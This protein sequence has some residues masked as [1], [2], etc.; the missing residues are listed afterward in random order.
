M[1]NKIL[2]SLQIGTQMSSCAIFNGLLSLLFLIISLL[3][4]FWGYIVTQNYNDSLETA[5]CTV[6][7]STIINKCSR[8]NKYT[9]ACTSQVPQWTTTVEFSLKNGWKYA[10][11]DST[12]GC[13]TSVGRC[14]AHFKFARTHPV[15]KSSD[16]F[17]DQTLGIVLYVKHDVLGFYISAYVFLSLMLLFAIITI[18]LITVMKKESIKD[19]FFRS[20]LSKEKEKEKE[21]EELDKSMNMTPV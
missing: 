14:G 12:I 2:L 3:L 7:E 1:I 11:T 15:G 5:V 9:G 20:I 17:Y 6:T 4:Y 8:Y 21:K 16:C 19:F 13:S 18:I 10:Q